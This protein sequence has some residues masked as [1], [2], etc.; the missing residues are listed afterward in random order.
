MA[1][2]EIFSE[3]SGQLVQLQSHAAFFPGS[4]ILMQDTLGN[5]LIDMLDG[6]RIGVAGGGTVTAGNGGLKLFHSSLQRGLIGLVL[7]VSNFRK[8]DTLLCG[9]DVG[10]GHTSCLQDR[11]SAAYGSVAFIQN[12]I[13][14]WLS[15][16]I[17]PFFKFFSGMDVLRACMDRIGCQVLFFAAKILHWL[18]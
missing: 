1:R 13:I 4:G 7:L 5:C 18:L 10:H 11:G 17:N 14:A 6:Q 12:C 3:E 15:R 16:K 2:K 9:L 8:L